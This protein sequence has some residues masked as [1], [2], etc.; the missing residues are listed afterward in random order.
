MAK[1]LGAFAD[2]FDAHLKKPDRRGGRAAPG[3]GQ[4]RP[5]APQGRRRHGHL[6]AVRRVSGPRR[7][8]EGPG[9]PDRRDGPAGGREVPRPRARPG[10]P[11]RDD[12]DGDG[13]PARERAV[14]LEVRSGR[15][16]APS[17]A[18]TRP[19][20]SPRWT[21]PRTGP[22][23]RPTPTPPC[24]STARARSPAS[25]ASAIPSPT[26]APT[27]WRAASRR[28]GLPGLRLR[29][30]Q[31][32][33]PDLL[34]RPVRR[35]LGGPGRGGAEIVA[36]PTASPATV[37]PAARAARHR[38][39][40]VSSTWRD[41]AT[42]YEP[43]GMVAARVEGPAGPGPRTGPELCRPRLV[44]VLQDGKALRERYGERVGFHY[45]PRE[46]MGLFWSN[47]PATTVGAMVRSMGARRSTPRSGGTAGCRTPPG[48]PGARP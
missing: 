37:L 25:T 8:A 40:V 14:P 18:S 43:T 11:A 45:E 22:R 9:R 26:S 15:P 47:D 4:G 19:T 29:L 36:W 48:R 34:G 7:A 23:G 13:G 3:P 42:V 41:N 20:S 28:G 6:R 38:Y 16:S 35:R 12:G 21:W 1:D 24:S 27:S 30:R 31:A 44:G 33:R 10:D 5:A 39:Y 46:D 32:G 17:P 2:W